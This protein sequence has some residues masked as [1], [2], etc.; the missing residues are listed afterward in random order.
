MTVRE[1]E[2][3]AL[4]Y[5]K[6]LPVAPPSRKII[7]LAQ[8]HRLYVNALRS[9]VDQMRDTGLEAAMETEET[10]DWIDLRIRIKKTWK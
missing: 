10:A 9:I 1:T 4:R 8:D 6:R 3:L 5:Q 7:S 2:A